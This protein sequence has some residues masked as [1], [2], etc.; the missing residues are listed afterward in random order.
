MATV[1]VPPDAELHLETRHFLTTDGVPTSTVKLVGMTLSPLTSYTLYVSGYFVPH[2][3]NPHSSIFFSEQLLQLRLQEPAWPDI[4]PRI[5]HLVLKGSSDVEKARAATQGHRLKPPGLCLCQLCS[6]LLE[7]PGVTNLTVEG[8]LW[9]ICHKETCCREELQHLAHSVRRAFKRISLHHIPH[10]TSTKTYC[11]DILQL[12]SSLDVFEYDLNITIS[13][14][15]QESPLRSSPFTP[16]LNPHTLHVQGEHITTWDLRH[17]LPQFPVNTLRTLVL[18]EFV[19]EELEYMVN[20]MQDHT[21]SL[22]TIKM[23]VV[24]QQNEINMESKDDLIDF[25][26]HVLNSKNTAHT[27]FSKLLYRL[28]KA[29]ALEITIDMPVIHQHTIDQQKAAQKMLLQLV[30]FA[31]MTLT[32]LKLVFNIGTLEAGHPCCLLGP[33]GWR[34]LSIFIEERPIETVTLKTITYS[35]DCGAPIDGW[36]WSAGEIKYLRKHLN[37]GGHDVHTL[38]FNTDCS[39]PADHAEI[40]LERGWARK[41]S[42]VHML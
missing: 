30:C 26:L 31:P 19:W 29:S 42:M 24:S 4:A 17:E 36:K 13:G 22:E 25:K 35:P 32:S 15:N 28:P 37:I 34:L 7:L 20:T 2:P 40:L 27:S 14:P 5:T 41:R 3:G 10:V 33:H 38:Q 21:Q 16:L 9:G 39:Q 11:S 1:T 8:A 18:E 12:A 23:S 6:W